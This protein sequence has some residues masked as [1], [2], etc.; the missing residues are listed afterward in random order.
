MRAGAPVMRDA[1]T[2][3][4]HRDDVLRAVRAVKDLLRQ[5]NIVVPGKAELELS[6]HY[7]MDKF[8]QTGLTVRVHDK[9]ARLEHLTATGAAPSHESRA[10]T[11]LDLVGY[12]V[13]GLMLARGW[14]DYPLV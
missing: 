3:T 11:V 7:G 12:S 4:N 13:I 9:L 14:F 1:V 10:D 6:H 5:A 8:G 2:A